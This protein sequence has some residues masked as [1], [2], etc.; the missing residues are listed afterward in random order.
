MAK[1]R[2]QELKYLVRE[3]IREE[4]SDIKL[5]YH[6]GDDKIDKFENKPPKNRRDNVSGFYFTKYKEKAKSFGKEVTTVELKIK[7]PFILGKSLVTDKMIE[8]Y[9]KELHKEN[10]YLDMYGSWIQEKCNYFKDKSQMSYTGL[11]GDAQ[12]KVFKSGEYDSVIDGDEICVFN[13]DDIIILNNINE[14][15][16]ILNLTQEELN[17]ILKGYIECALWTEE[18]RL[19]DEVTIDMDDEEDMDEIEKLIFLK[20]KFD[21]KTFTSFISEDID[22]DSRIDAYNDIKQFIKDSGNVAIKEAI[23]ENGLFKLGMDIWL[24]RNGHGSGFFDHNYENEEILI[25]S[26]KKLK[27]KNLIVG[28]DNKL[29]FE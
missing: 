4:I 23:N 3:I 5:W 1:I 18:E 8:I 21:K 13:S 19:H 6:G 25:K 7:K 16:K 9:R 17:E 11:N 29:Y 24:T 20:N 28:D 22:I 15:K 26:A 27:E 2:L 10:D 12:Q 14:E